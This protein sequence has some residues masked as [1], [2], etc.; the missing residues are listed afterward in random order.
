MNVLIISVIVVVVIFAIGLIFASLYKRASKEVSYVR[1]GLGGQKVIK[2]GGGLVL[3]ILHEVIPVNMNTLRLLVHRANEQ[4]LIT[5]DRMRVDVVAEFYVRVQPTAESI[6]NAAQTLGSRTLRPDEL[7]E[8]VEGKFV[9]ALRSV[10]AKM[11]MEELHEQ[12]EDFVKEVQNS[13]ALDLSKN[14]LELES[15]S[16]TGF[17][18]TGMEYFNPNNAFDAEGL[19]LLTREIEARKKIRNDIEQD[20]SVQIKNKNLEAEK[21]QLDIRRE[22]EYARMQQE[23]EV[24]IRRA[25]QTA[26]I[27]KETS[28]KEKQ[29]EQAKIVAQQEIQKSRILSQKAVEEEQI[30]KERSIETYKIDKEKAIKIAAQGKEIAIAEK[31]KEQSIANAE[32]AH[33]RAKAVE[34]EEKVIT[35]KEREIAERQKQIELI[36]AAKEAEREAIGL[37]VAAEAEKNAAKDKAE[38]LREEARGQADKI[39][40]TAEAE[41]EAEKVRAAAA[42]IRYAVEATGNRA[43]NDAA[44]VLSSEQVAMNVKMKIIENLSSIIRES[45]KPMENIDGIKIIQVDGLNSNGGS[46]AAAGANSNGGNLSDQIVNSALRYRAQAPLLDSLLK[47]VGIDGNDINAFTNI[48]QDS[49]AVGTAADTKKAKPIETIKDTTKPSVE[50]V[51]KPEKK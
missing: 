40:I 34:A 47:D 4:A 35:S 26:E 12:R 10:A 37:K 43:L 11:S 27:A 51:S 20:T 24:S 8:L 41:S 38:A 22:E 7:K 15:V 3:P 2:D 9:D 30:Q 36:Q 29:A 19:T 21:L 6:A 42:E 23:R 31:S 39:R 28:E 17:D 13:V 14:G 16:L 48:L 1:T 33:A 5:K 44:N 25:E 45:V 32:A 18:Q 50:K 49:K 46:A